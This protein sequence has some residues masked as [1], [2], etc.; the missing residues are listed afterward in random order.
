MSLGNAYERKIYYPVGE[1]FPREES[2]LVSSPPYGGQ[3]ESTGALGM[4]LLIV[5]DP[6]KSDGNR[7]YALGRGL[8]CKVGWMSEM[9]FC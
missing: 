6:L 5:I 8:H 4:H 2:P 9:C 3:A 7:P 1:S